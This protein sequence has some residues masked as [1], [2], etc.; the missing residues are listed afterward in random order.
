MCVLILQNPGTSLTKKKAKALWDTNPHGGGFAFVNN[1]Q[2]FVVRK[3]MKFDEWWAAYRGDLNNFPDRPWLLHMRIATHGTVDL[4]NVHPFRIT[5]DLVGG[6][7]GI[8]HNVPDYR[9]GRSDTRVFFEDVVTGFNET[10]LDSDAMKYMVERAIG[11]S[12]LAFLTKNPA[13][14]HQSYILNEKLGEW[15]EGMWFSNTYGL[16]QTRVSKYVTGK[17]Y[18]KDTKQWEEKPSTPATPHTGGYQVKI[19]GNW[20][21]VPFGW[22]NEDKWEDEEIATGWE[23]PQLPLPEKKTTNAE[24]QKLGLEKMVELRAK[25]KLHT[26]IGWTRSPWG[27]WCDRCDERITEAS[28]HCGCMDLWCS[29]HLEILGLCVEGEHHQ[30][31]QPRVIAICDLP[32]GDVRAEAQQAQ[33]QWFELHWKDIYRLDEARF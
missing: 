27:Y 1:S 2:E 22:D 19:N 8:I 14:Q 4:D 13:L 20:A 30:L 5:D 33:D 21:W 15:D 29:E 7:N 11:N 32:E 6:H 12:K 18:N 23:T 31:L 10:W 3:F 25:V 16:A 26:D 9:D 17:V 28:I 24:A